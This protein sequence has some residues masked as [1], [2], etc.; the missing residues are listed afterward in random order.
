L[1]DVHDSVGFTDGG[2]GIV[3]ATRLG[4]A[5]AE[6][7]AKGNH[8]VAYLGWKK[9][10]VLGRFRCRFADKLRSHLT[11]E[12]LGLELLGLSL[13]AVKPKP[14]TAKAL[15]AETR[16][17]LLRQ[18][19][20]AV[21]VRRN[22]AVAQER[23]IKENEYATAIAVEIKKREVREAQLEA[24]RSV[25]E[26]ELQ[27]RRNEMAGK[28]GLEE[29]NK[30][31]V[32]L[33]SVNA[34]GEADA[35]AYGLSAMMRSLGDGDPRILQALASVG[36]NPGQLMAVAFRDLAGNAAKIGQLNVSPDLLRE[37]LQPQA[38]R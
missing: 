13:L 2:G 22:A 14:E 37:M 30:E 24:E 5:T 38:S 23:T 4:R 29:Q 15:E 18:A 32:A 36:M 28:V 10:S 3:P 31:L 6:W 16:E 27:L 20:E 9:D 19:D 11:I 35:K 12:E 1:S 21:Y 34:R 7:T 17:A 26:R 8:Y 25:Q 33:S